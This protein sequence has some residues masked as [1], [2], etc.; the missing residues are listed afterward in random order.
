MDSIMT[1]VD[2]TL[3]LTHPSIPPVVVNQI[4]EDEIAMSS[5]TKLKTTLEHFSTVVNDGV[6]EIPKDVIS[7]GVRVWNDYVVGFFIKHRLLYPLVKEALA[8]QWRTKAN[9]SM[10]V[11]K[12]L[13]YFKVL[14]ESDRQQVLEIGSLFIVGKLFV[15]KP[16][17]QEVE[18][19]RKQANGKAPMRGPNAVDVTAQGKTNWMRK[20]KGISTPPPVLSN[21]FQGLEVNDDEEII[22]E[23]ELTI[24]EPIELINNEKNLSMVH[25]VW[26]QLL[27]GK[28]LWTMTPPQDCSWVWRCLLKSREEARKFV[29]YSLVNGNDTLLWHDLWCHASPLLFNQDALQEW[30]LTFPKDAK[31]LAGH[32]CEHLLHTLC[33]SNKRME[34]STQQPLIQKDDEDILS[35]SSEDQNLITQSFSSSFGSFLVADDDIDPINHVN[36]FYREFMVE[37]KK[38]WLLAGPAIFTGICQYSLG[39]ITQVFAGQLGTLELA[40]V[41]VENSVIAG[42]SFGVMMGMGSAL[43]TLCGQAYGAGQLDMLGIYMQRS[44]VILNTTALLLSFIYI[45]AAP[46]LKLIG[47]EINIAQAAGTFA[48]WMIPQLF[49]YAVNFPIAKFLQAQSKMNVMAVI[50]IAALILHT[51]FS[52]LFM[53]KLGWGLVGLAVV[54]NASW[55]FINVSQL[56]YIFSGTCGRAWS[57]FS[58]KAFQ[59][60]WGFVRLSIASAIML[61]LDMWYFTALIL[62]AGYVKNP[63]VQVDGLSVCMNIL[64]WAVMVAFGFNAATSVRVSNE[65]GAGHPRTAKFSVVVVVVFSCLIG[66]IIS[67]IL[68]ISRKQYPYA[69]TSSPDVRKIV[70][71]LTPLLAFSIVINN[72]QP[73]LSGVAVGAGWQTLV[74]YVN[75]GSYY[76]FGVP[77]GLILGY[78]LDLGVM[79][80]WFGMI[81]GTVLQTAILLLITYKTNWNKEASDA[82]VRVKQWSRE[83]KHEVNDIENKY[84]KSSKNQN[85][86]SM[87]NQC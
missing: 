21:R 16:W 33:N 11:D 8:K 71:Q 75:V 22:E 2:S 65:L 4:C 24:V 64:G 46:L 76:V 36:D 43:E 68:I 34:T 38:L 50:A 5:A 37:T 12:D 85:G 41:S 51:F 72:V 27:R 26:Q 60:L 63:E 42:F 7:E 32:T 73:V 47:Q 59:N 84:S 53:F 55:W 13:F 9:Y 79:G 86:S 14:D 56:L 66:M 82:K 1:L 70:Y 23:G 29:K 15:V 25:W 19:Q 61:C 52:W 80:I 31:F 69:F 3:P 78:K 49:A 83:A 20:D 48:V 10:V 74:A 81:T 44:W 54:L 58:I 30:G 40:A 45:F 28:Y 67:L 62:F 57:G 17:S 39:A 77:L 35:S 6:A 18:K 87:K